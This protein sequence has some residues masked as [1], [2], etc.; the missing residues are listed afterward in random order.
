MKK[1]TENKKAASR[2]GKSRIEQYEKSQ[3][4]K[5]EKKEVSKIPK[6]II[7]YQKKDDGDWNPMYSDE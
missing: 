1:N 5:I 7:G 3:E 4:K 6:R 2:K